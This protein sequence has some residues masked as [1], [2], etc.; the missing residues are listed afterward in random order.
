MGDV[1]EYLNPETLQQL[2]NAFTAVARVS[3]RICRADGSPLTVPSA[4]VSSSADAPGEEPL[5]EAA[6][7]GASS[8][9]M[10]NDEVIGRITLDIA[11]DETQTP[12]VYPR[13]LKLVGLVSGLIARLC[14][15]EQQLRSRVEELATLYRLMGAFSGQRDPQSLLELIAKTVAETMGAMACSIRLLSEDGTELIRSATANLSAE[16]LQKGPVLLRESPIDQEALST[17]KSVKI[18]DM[19]NDPRVL[20]PAEAHR[21]GIVSGL[22]APMTYK[23]Q[24]QGAIRLYKAKRHEFDW[25]EVSL[26]EAIAAQAAAAIVNARLYTEAARSAEIQR[27]LRLAGEVQR[28]MI[29]AASPQIEGFDIAAIYVPCFELG[30]DFYDFLPLP[31][32]NLGLA[33]CDVVGKGVPASLLMA[34]IRASLRA[35]ARSIYEMSEVLRQ[36]NCDLCADTLI[37]E[38]ATLFYGVID[39]STRRFTY[40]NAGHT[41]P[42]LI[43]DG[44]ICHLSTGGSVLGIDERLHW[45][46]QAF[47][48][49]S[50]DVLLMHT[51]G[52][53]EALNFQDEP[54]GRQRVEQ[55]VLAAID[56][57]RDAEGIAKHVLWEMRRFAGLQT[58]PDDLTLIAVRVQ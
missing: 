45:Q 56:L 32:N 35:H 27:Q 39:T 14:Q 52:L 57:G 44:R 53:H 9:I 6:S 50:G 42:L 41:P 25:F 18:V 7:Y 34:S 1:T 22:C 13:H 5:L 55:A 4:A 36:V 15:R 21:E 10:V 2:Q 28:R 31:E 37:S 43:R 33:V 3:I 46:Q 51:D 29:P 26:L 23:G 19:Q 30:G 8:P 20:Y 40:A 11:G 17:G 48:L 12:M 16:Y 38:F 49:F 54:F 47:D 58:R 24:P